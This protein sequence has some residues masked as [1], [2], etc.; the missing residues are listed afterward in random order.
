LKIE[1]WK[2]FK[3]CLGVDQIQPRAIPMHPHQLKV[4]INTQDRY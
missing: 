3:I 4:E 1:I 2:Q